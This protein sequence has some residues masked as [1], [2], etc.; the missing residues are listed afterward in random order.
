MSKADKEEYLKTYHED[1][2]FAGLE[3]RSIAHKEQMFHQEVAIWIINSKRELLLEK[4][5]ME[6]ALNP[7]RYSLCAGHIVGEDTVQ[8]TI[9]R[10]AQE[11]IG[12]DIHELNYDYVTVVKR[13]EPS[14]YCF[15]HHY[16]LFADVDLSLLAIQTEELSE[17]IYMD[18]EE[19]KRRVKCNDDSVALKWN[20][21]YQ[22]VFR[23]IDK[24][25][26]QYFAQSN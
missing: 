14:N 26:N 5:S 15:S 24:R 1:G 21:A 12:L 4:R 9:I 16:V 11:E 18:Y 13:K 25:I 22:E 6:K 2:T 8:D 20:D 7:G 10:E 19:F 23:C 3:L 17:V